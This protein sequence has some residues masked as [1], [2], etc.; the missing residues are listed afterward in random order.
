MKILITT[1]VIVG[2]A[3]C[4]IT[5]K[6]DYQSEIEKLA[7]AKSNIPFVHKEGKHRREVP[8]EEELEAGIFGESYGRGKSGSL[9][10]LLRGGHYR[11]DKSPLKRHREGKHHGIN[12]LEEHALFER[13]KLVNKEDMYLSE[14][15]L[16]TIM[17]S[18]DKKKGLSK[19]HYEGKETHNILDPKYKEILGKKKDVLPIEKNVG[20]L[21]YNIKIDENE[22][23]E[24]I[25]DFGDLA[26]KYLSKTKKERKVLMKKLNKAFKT[27]AAKM[28]LNFGKIIP[29]VVQSWAE[30]M[31]HIQVNPECDQNKAVQC[32]DPME[33]YETLYFNPA[34]LERFSCRFEL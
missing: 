30:V 23:D 33:G 2:L 11:H 6:E 31:R 12:L 26:D 32:L 14:E 34:C 18:E 24:I 29:P 16:F 9:D 8:L 21:S 17:D 1:L 22:I 27:T 7:G 13:N 20:D 19:K 10:K 28:L 4:T 5:T 25:D 15:D 3:S